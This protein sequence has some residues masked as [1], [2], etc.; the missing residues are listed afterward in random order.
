[1][2][3]IKNFS[4]QNYAIRVSVNENGEPEFCASDITNILGYPNGRDA[5]ARHCKSDG[6]VKRDMGVITGMK[7]D[8]TPAY[9]TVNT[10]FITEGNLYRLILRSEKPEAEPFEKWVCDEVLP[11]IR[12]TGS[13]GVA[14]IPASFAEAL[15]LAADQARKLEEQERQME[16]DAPKVLFAKSV[17]G[18]RDSILVSGLSKILKQ[19]GIENMGQNRLYE[20]LR[21]HGYLCTKGEYYNQPTQMSMELGLFELKETAVHKPNG[22]ILI[23][24]TTLVTGKGQTYFVNKFLGG[25]MQ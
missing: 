22:D 9:Q 7:Q 11:T 8:G 17:E 18:S 19:N 2:N 6:V 3:E 4:F 23:S 20:I 1:M 25:K 15:Q 10:T 14:K 21:H 12:K 13:Y 24:F 16:L 5:I